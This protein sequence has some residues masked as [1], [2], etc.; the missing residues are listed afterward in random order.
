[1]KKNK[2]E[3]ELIQREVIRLLQKSKISNYKIG[4]ETGIT[5]ATIGN[6]RKN[7]TKPTDAN[8]KILIKYFANDNSIN[9]THSGSGSNFTNVGSTVNI[10]NGDGK[11]EALAQER[12]QRIEAKDLT[13]AERIQMYNKQIDN[14]NAMIKHYIEILRQKEQLLL[15]KDEEINNLRNETTSWQEKYVSA[16][17]QND[18]TLKA[19]FVKDTNFNDIESNYREQLKLKDDRIDKLLEQIDKLTS[20]IASQQ[21]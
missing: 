11:H 5:E 3:L 12:K 19:A 20:I 4:K 9:Q 6:Y 17:T 2:K 21:K 10:S 7:K 13:T 14:N 8:A 16:K 18:D 1:M 15:K